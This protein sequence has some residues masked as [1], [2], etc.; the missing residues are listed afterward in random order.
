MTPGTFYQTLAGMFGAAVI[1]FVVLR[2]RDRRRN[3]QM[4]PP[5]D[6]PSWHPDRD[7]AAGLDRWEED[8]FYALTACWGDSGLGI[9]GIEGEGR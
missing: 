7:P 6:A 2:L 8:E 9:L 3:R 1:A 5:G 4:L